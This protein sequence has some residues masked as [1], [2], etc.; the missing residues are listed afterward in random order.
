MNSVRSSALIEQVVRL[1]PRRIGEDR[2]RAERAR[3]VFHAAGIDRADLA[4]GEP[5]R[6][7]LDRIA[8][9]APERPRSQPS[10]ASASVV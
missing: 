7:R 1:P 6:R 2:A 9:E 3:P 5:L 8:R 10:V 4:R